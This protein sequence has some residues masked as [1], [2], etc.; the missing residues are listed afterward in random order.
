MLQ[1]VIFKL[2]YTSQV[3]QNLSNLKVT[4]A[5]ASLVNC[6]SFNNK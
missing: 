6:S 1:I 5:E 3:T 4:A 2:E